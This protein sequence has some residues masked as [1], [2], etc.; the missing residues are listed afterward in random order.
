[1]TAWTSRPLRASEAAILRHPDQR[2][3]WAPSLVVHLAAPAEHLVVAERLARLAAEHAILGARLGRDE[4]IAVPEP[5]PLEVLGDELALLRT[6]FD[7]AVGPPVRAALAPDGRRL[8]VVGHHAALDGR[9][10]ALIAQPL[11]G[12]S[13]PTRADSAAGAPAESQPRVEH[14]G[15]SGGGQR[16]GSSAL[17]LIARPAQRVAPSAQA[18]RAETFVSTELPAGRGLRVA[19]LAAAVTAAAG[20][21]NTD[22]GAPWG[23]IGLTIPIG[24]P[25]AIGNVSTHRRVDLELPA[26]VARAVAAALATPEAPL[27]AVLSRGRARLLRLAAPLALRLSDSLLVSNLGLVDLPGASGVDFYPQARG[28]SAVAIG[29]C[30]PAGGTPR[31]TLRSRDLTEHDARALLDAVVALLE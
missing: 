10:L 23:R 18:P 9:A 12:N 30:T 6:R 5:P 26:D 31:L 15:P 7:L 29:A 25:P 8:A 28:R 3:P 16:H 19:P 24:G 2:T 11:R 17:R 20:A 4:W 27:G 13:A 1:M 14:E 22:R 21:W